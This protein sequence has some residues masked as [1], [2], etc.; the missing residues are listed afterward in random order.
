MID[1][2]SIAARDLARSFAFYER[3]LAPLGD[4]KLVV[5]ERAIGFGKSHSELWLNLRENLPAVSLASGAH[6]AFRARNPQAFNAFHAAAL[7]GGGTDGGAPG[8]R[9]YGAGPTS[10]APPS[11]AISKAIA[12]RR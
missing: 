10:T 5:R 9:P 4:A 6:V 7:A 1:H 8:R 2:V 12:S 11:C 3:A